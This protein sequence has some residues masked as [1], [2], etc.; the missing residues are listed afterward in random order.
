MIDEITRCLGPPRGAAAAVGRIEEALEYREKEEHAMRKTLAL[1]G[2]VSAI[3][4][5]AS[6]ARADVSYVVDAAAPW[7]G[8]M[9]VFDPTLGGAFLWGSGWGTADLTAVFN[10]SQTELTLGPNTIDDPSPYWYSP[11]GGPG[12]VGVKTM[13][14]NFFVTA[15]A[16]TLAGETVTFSGKV[17]TNTLTSA[18]LARA[19]IRDF[20]PDY[21]TFVESA[22]E[23]LPGDFSVSLFT[24]PSPGRHIQY[25]FNF[26][27]P[28]VWITDVAPYGTV[29]LE[30]IPPVVQEDAD[31]NSD[32]AVDG[33]D[34]LIWQRGVGLTGQTGIK[35]NGNANSDDVVDGADLTIWGAQF[36]PVGATVAA[37]AVPEPASQGLAA[38]GLILLATYRRSRSR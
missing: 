13:D 16:G 11:S 3:W 33:T 35:T 32:D 24:D 7:E 17:L 31:F 22:V 4:L 30:A 18:H 37:S 1:V 34:L 21:S 6:G 15:P 2:I 28:N 36:G 9:N 25:G 12:A 23:L 26:N 29:T 27:G 38:A 8:Y 10:G 5:P 19:F 20:A 14:A